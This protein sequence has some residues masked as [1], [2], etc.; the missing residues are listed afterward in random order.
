MKEIKFSNEECT[1]IKGVIDTLGIMSGYMA[2]NLCRTEDGT[3]IKFTRER[4]DREIKDIN[5][6]I[7]N[8]EKIFNKGCEFVPSKEGLSAIFGEGLSGAKR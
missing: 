8:L 5:T 4:L 6:N 3:V 2:E 1:Q 7:I